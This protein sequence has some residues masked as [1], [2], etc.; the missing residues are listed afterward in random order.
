MFVFRRPVRF[1]EVD[2][3]RLVFFARHLEYCHDALE[4]L[5]AAL[6]GGYATL[7]GARDLGIPTVRADVTYHAPLRYG[8]TVRHEIRVRHIGR[9]S[10]RVQHRLLRDGDSVLCASVEHVFLVARLSTLTPEPI[11]A[12]VRAL[13]EAHLAAEDQP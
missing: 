2:A 7:T 8:D 12:D 10:V 11:P 5:F 6:D 4:A 13:L 9:T 1:V 3:A